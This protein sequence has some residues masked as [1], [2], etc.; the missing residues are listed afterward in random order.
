LFHSINALGN[1]IDPVLTDLILHSLQK[2]SVS[3]ACDESKSPPIRSQAIESIATESATLESYARSMMER[4]NT[5][6]VPAIAQIVPESEQKSF[7]TRVLMNLG[8]LDSRLH[9]VGMHEAVFQ[10]EN[11]K[12]QELFKQAIPSIPQMMIPRWKRKLYEPKA[13]VLD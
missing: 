11:G 3:I 4:E 9:L 6:L 8:L 10:S 12:E 7:N 5:F 1:D 2:R 13:N